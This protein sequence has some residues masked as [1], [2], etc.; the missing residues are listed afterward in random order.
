LV[1]L[2]AVGDLEFSGMYLGRYESQRQ[3][4]QLFEPGMRTHLEGT[5]SKTIL[6]WLGVADITFGNLETTLAKKK[7]YHHAR[8]TSYRFRA[9]PSN[10]EGLRRLGFDV[11]SLANNHVLDYGDEAFIETLE[12]LDKAG[13]KHVGAGLS[14]RE[15]LTPAKFT[16]GKERIGFLGFATVYPIIGAAATDRLGVA[17]IRNKIIYEFESPRLPTDLRPG[18]TKPPK[19]IE[20]AM[21]E[22]VK[23]ICKIIQRAKKNSDFLVVSIHWGREYDDVP[24]EG[25]RKLGH[26]IID[27][28]ADMVIGHHP[29]TA[30]AIEVYDG[31]YIFYSLGNF[32]MQVEWDIARSEAY[33]N[34]ALMVRVAVED[35]AT[36][37]VEIL[38][39]RTDKTGLPLITEDYPNV[40]KHLKEMS[41][42]LNTLIVPKGQFA[43]VKPRKV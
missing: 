3:N 8:P 43:L 14:L 30:Q 26:E 20:Q 27:S 40:L 23:S 38:P 32:A 24:S 25:Q 5:D 35:G 21:E 37:G 11:V 18:Y 6:E 19:I 29:H 34:E 13:V 15:A 12:S 41:S 28:G 39:T 9:D 36:S 7:Q 31:K 22:D 33:L 10:A 4:S 17:S 1:K 2:T 16:V 42:P